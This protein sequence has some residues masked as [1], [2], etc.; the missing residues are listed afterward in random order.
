MVTVGIGLTVILI[1]EVA[2]GQTVEGTFVVNVTTAKPDAI[3]GVNMVVKALVG[4]NVPEGELQVAEVAE[5]PMVPVSVTVPPAQTLAGAPALSVAG[6]NTY[7][8]TCAVS[9]QPL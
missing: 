2:A 8:V 1:D 3:V 6:G 4:L 5:P 7:T 9:L